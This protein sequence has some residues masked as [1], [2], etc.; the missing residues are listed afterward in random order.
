MPRSLLRGALRAV[1]ALYF[2]AGFAD[3]IITGFGAEEGNF[4]CVRSER[5]FGGR[6]EPLLQT[7]AIAYL[8][9]QF[10]NSV[11]ADF[12][13]DAEAAGLAFGGGGPRCA[14]EQAMSPQRPVCEFGRVEI[15]E[16]ES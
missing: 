9:G 16:R 12:A 8:R 13:D 4:V 1:L 3:E 6:P 2:L 10:T 14:G 15:I 7:T 11:V 5:L